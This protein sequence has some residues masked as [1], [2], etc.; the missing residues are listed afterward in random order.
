[1]CYSVLMGKH[2]KYAHGGSR[3]L[4][5]KVARF[6]TEHTAD[7]IGFDAGLYTFGEMLAILRAR[8]ADDDADCERFLREAGM[9]A[10]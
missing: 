7:F 3:Q 4:A 2:N 6:L 8:A 1:M 10:T 5:A 9:D